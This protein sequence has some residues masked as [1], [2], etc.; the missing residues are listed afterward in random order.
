MY[1]VRALAN[2]RQV[3]RGERPWIYMYHRIF[4]FPSFSFW[5]K[6]PSFW[7]R[8]NSSYETRTRSE[9]IS[10]HCHCM[11]QYRWSRYRE[12]QGRKQLYP[13][14]YNPVNR[15][16]PSPWCSGSKRTAA[17]LST[18]KP[19]LLFTRDIVRLSEP[20]YSRYFHRYDRYYP[21]PTQCVESMTQEYPTRL[22]SAKF[23]PRSGTIAIFVKQIFSTLN[24]STS[25]Y[26][27]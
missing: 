20:L 8:G 12:W 9:R 5:K 25:A 23:I 2:K 27:H 15:T 7:P 3:Y 26:H 16:T 11:L 17:S 10:T 18:G 6:S 22:C 24:F 1:N 13:V 21:S 4:R 14:I 19:S